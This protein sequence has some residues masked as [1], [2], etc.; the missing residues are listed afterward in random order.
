MV[1][2][3]L[4]GLESPFMYSE[5]LVVWKSKTTAEDWNKQFG[6]QCNWLA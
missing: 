2:I 5:Y 3:L 6:S 1:H 4:L